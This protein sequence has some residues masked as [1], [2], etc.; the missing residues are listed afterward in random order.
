MH[1]FFQDLHPEHTSLVA[2]VVKILEMYA[3][4]SQNAS[5]LFRELNGPQEM[6]ARLAYE[7]GADLDPPATATAALATTAAA[8]TV[9]SPGAAAASSGGDTTMTPAD[10]A[11]TSTATSATAPAAPAATQPV[12]AAASVS[13]AAPATVVVGGLPIACGR[14]LTFARKMLMKFLLRAVTLSSFGASNGP[15]SRPSDADAMRLYRCLY[16]LLSAPVD[17][18]GGLFSLAA[19]VM[20]DLLHHDPLQYRLLQEAG[21]PRAYL[22]AVNVSWVRFGSERPSTSSSRGRPVTACH[23]IRLTLSVDYVN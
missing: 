2:T 9:A 20:A 10:V 12:P 5:T 14:P 6:I 22:D 4:F 8:A 13:A 17:F 3:D 1:C 23:I 11:T 18:G 21:L 19:S 16:A 15:A 7:V